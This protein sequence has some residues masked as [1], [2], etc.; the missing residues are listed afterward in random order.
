MKISDLITSLGAVLQKRGDLDVRVG[1]HANDIEALTIEDDLAHEVG[2]APR[3][4]LRI[5]ELA[6]A[7]GPL[8][9]KR[10]GGLV[11]ISPP[12]SAA[13][14][15]RGVFADQI[16]EVHSP[17]SSEEFEEGK[18]YTIEQVNDGV[19]LRWTG[20]RPH[21]DHKSGYVTIRLS[22]SAAQRIESGT[23]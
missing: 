17:I 5:R 20:V 16:L 11:G 8:E 23:G 4:F 1:Q 13:A 2:E 3:K 12:I 10:V 9:F 19:T 6:P 15:P 18:T 21:F 7:A 14:E 22:V